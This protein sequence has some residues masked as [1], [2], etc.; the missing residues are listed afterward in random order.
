MARACVIDEIRRIARG[1]CEEVRA[2]LPRD[3]CASTSRMRLVNERRRLQA[4][5]GAFASHASLRDPMQFAMNE[6]DEPLEALPSPLPRCSGWS[7]D[8]GPIVSNAAI[9]LPSSW[10]GR[11]FPHLRAGGSQMT[12]S[13]NWGGGL[14]A[15]QPHP[16]DSVLDWNLKMVST[17][18]R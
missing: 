8:I 6:R 5:P 2:I 14:L 1:N 16:A 18:L 11:H 12:L 9:M 13:A 4:V 17:L 10:F 7:G 15:A 3:A